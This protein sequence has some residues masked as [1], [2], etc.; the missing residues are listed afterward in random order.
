VKELKVI[1]NVY[2]LLLPPI[3]WWNPVK[4]LKARL[5]ENP[6]HNRTLRWNPVKELKELPHGTAMARRDGR[7]IR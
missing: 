5:G 3:R 6:R 7:G 2:F 4:E 1:K